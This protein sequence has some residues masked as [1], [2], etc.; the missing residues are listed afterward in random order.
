MRRGVIMHKQL[1]IGLLLG[2]VIYGASCASLQSEPL[3][4]KAQKA[5]RIALAQE[6]VRE[7]EVIYRLQEPAK[8]EFAEDSSGPGKLTTDVRVGTRTLFEM[9]DSINRLNMISVDARWVEFRD[10]LKKLHQERI[11]LVHEMNQVSKTLLAGPQPDVNYDKLTA[12][13]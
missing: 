6:F 2:F 1:W 12:P 3:A 4:G 9:N 5:A 13:A 11:V 8:R 7:L 10:A